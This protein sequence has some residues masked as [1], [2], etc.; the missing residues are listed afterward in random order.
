MAKVG[1]VASLKSSGFPRL[2]I[3][4]SS[5]AQANLHLIERQAYRR[6]RTYR[7]LGTRH[8]ILKTWYCTMV[9]RDDVTFL[10]TMTTFKVV[11]DA[12]TT[13]SWYL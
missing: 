9:I 12:P 10:W 6:N 11:R 1:Y 3:E 2:G 13:L 5:M 4:S 7:N 8:K